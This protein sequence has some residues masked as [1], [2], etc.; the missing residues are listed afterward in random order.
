MADKKD[1]F[2]HTLM[3]STALV[4]LAA[5]STSIADEAS[6]TKPIRV[7]QAE[8]PTSAASSGAQRLEEIVVTAKQMRPTDQTTATGIEMLLIETPQAITVVTP[9]MLDVAGARSIYDAV[10]LIPGVEASGRGYSVDRIFMR[11]S[12]AFDHR[13]N[14]APLKAFQSLDK[15]IVDRIE[16]VRGPATVLYGVTSGFGG[17]INHIL[18]SPT[19][20]FNAQL[21]VEVGDFD[22]QRYEADIGGPIAG[23]DGRLRG[24]LVGA[25]E[26]Y[27][28]FMDVVDISNQKYS[29][30]GSLA[31]D[32]T[33]QTS[34]TI[35]F[36]DSKTEEDPYD[37]GF[38]I[39]GPDG[40]QR[41]PT[42]I[43]ADNYYF[44]D[45]SNS[46]AEIN[47]S[48]LIA[49]VRHDFSN[50]WKL[51]VQGTRSEWDWTISYFY[52]FGPAGA[53]ALPDNEVYL[54]T[55]DEFRDKS[56][57]SLVM[58]LGGDFEAF[59][60]DVDFHVGFQYLADQSPATFWRKRSVFLGNINIFE[61]G[62]GVLANGSPIVNPDRS[63]LPIVRASSSDNSLFTY[64]VQFLFHATEKLQI[65]AGYLLQDADESGKTTV[66]GG[67]TLNPPTATNFSYTEGVPR[68]GVTYDVI[69]DSGPFSDGKIYYSY[70]EGFSSNGAIFDNDGKQIS[71]PQ[72]MDQ[73]EIGFKFE[74]LNGRVGG[75]LA[76]YQS[77]IV[78]QPVSAS[79]LGGFANS[80]SVLEG[81]RDI[82]GVEFEI[83]GALTDEWNVAANYA[84]TDTKL[85]DPNFDFTSQ[86]RSVPEHSAALYSSYEWLDGG[87]AGLRIGGGIVYKGDYEF[88]NGLNRQPRFGNLIDGSYT[89]IDLYGSYRGFT[90]ALAGL[91]LF[92]NVENL[93]DEDYFMAKEDHPGFGIMRGNP[94]RITGG[95]RFNFR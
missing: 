24:R 83:V 47:Q 77:K 53:Y 59:G 29:V 10:N 11:G 6:S 14:G 87:L 43:P 28:V 56:D 91:E 70:S 13:V 18:K 32:F 89:R 67:N 73:H 2:I 85:S 84:Y 37:A 34:A 48:F 57:V 41:L 20:Q 51:K 88:V 4:S 7:A 60:K 66:L 72:S 23:S 50:D 90:G 16:V 45:T 26:D 42:V 17:E 71:E 1:C 68:L 58:S 25:Y 22:F 94:R 21:G 33:D 75:A 95:F 38:T 92:A 30:M 78:N 52:P 8:S 82:K 27:G 69:D 36:F 40:Q 9:E 61:G 63:Q 74:M 46:W 65:L 19:R 79:F 55:Y 12:I 39:Q 49:E 64:S 93:T 15:A 35:H 54:Y 80:G 44:S 86:I 3:A 62:Q 81:E 31:F 5:A 76:A